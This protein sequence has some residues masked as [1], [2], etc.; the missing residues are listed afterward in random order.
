MSDTFLEAE[1]V[2]RGRRIRQERE[3]QGWS[4]RILAMQ[5]EVGLQT[6]VRI[7]AGNLGVSVE[8][9]L[10]VERA[11]GLVA[12]SSEHSSD[13]GNSVLA[14]QMLHLDSPKTE[15]AVERA[16]QAACEVLDEF[17]AT[18][19]PER[20]GISS[21]FQGL[22]REHLK[23][24]LCGASAARQGISLKRV[25][26][27]DD[28]LGGPPAS[29]VGTC[30]GWVLR[31][32][33]TPLVLQGARTILLDAEDLDPYTSREAAAQGFRAYIESERHPQGMVDAVPVFLDEQREHYSF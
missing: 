10:R 20:D 2:R 33:G 14:R 23:A 9:F 4:L 12:H 16:A 28:W 18:A 13:E 26:Y 21:N 31:I 6:L 8:N 15:D 27:S 32:R 7:E 1:L 19:H 22:L 17:L 29:R 11:V 3:R 5:A 30:A 25:V 24:M